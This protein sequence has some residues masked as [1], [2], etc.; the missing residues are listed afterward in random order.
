MRAIT[1]VNHPPAGIRAPGSRPWSDA[2]I[3]SGAQEPA[4]LQPRHA[5]INLPDLA[6]PGCG[7][8]LRLQLQPCGPA[9]PLA[10]T[11]REP[12]RGPHA[13]ATPLPFDRSVDDFKRRLLRRA[14]GQT[15]GVMSRAAQALGLK[16]TTFVAMAHR[17]GVV[18]KAGHKNNGDSSAATIE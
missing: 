10:V 1:S 12:H 7:T 15:G 8:S 14:L 3:W 16:Y 9:P 13:S 11:P 17:L 2:G 6:C 18:D 4:A 5:E